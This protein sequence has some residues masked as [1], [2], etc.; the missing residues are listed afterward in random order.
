MKP[1]LNGP[2]PDF[3]LRSPDGVIMNMKTV[4][5][6]GPAVVVL[7]PNINHQDSSYIVDN[8]RDDFNEFKALRAGIVTVF[9]SDEEAVAKMHSEHELQYPIFA[10]PDREVFRK[11][12][13]MDGLI[14]KKPRKYACVINTEGLITK[15]FRSIDANRFSRQALYALRDQMGR[16]ALSSKK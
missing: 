11:F 1:I 4:L 10:D 12:R 5:S 8:F 2:A 9:N 15:A 14:L 16:S 6:G 3:T 7:L 13:A